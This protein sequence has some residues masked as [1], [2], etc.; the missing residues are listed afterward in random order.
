MRRIEALGFDSVWTGDHVSFHSPMYESLTLL[1]TY[2]PITTPGSSPSG[3]WARA[4]ENSV[5]SSDV[6]VSNSAPAPPA[7][8][9]QIRSAGSS[10]GRES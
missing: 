6:S 3:A 9:L 7:I 10:G 1:A 2:V 8:G 4:A 5:P